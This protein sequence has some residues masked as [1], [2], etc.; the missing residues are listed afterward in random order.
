MLLLPEDIRGTRSNKINSIAKEILTT[1]KKKWLSEHEALIILF[2]DDLLP[3]VLP[4]QIIFSANF[5][6]LERRF[7]F[8]LPPK[9]IAN[10]KALNIFKIFFV[11][12][13]RND[14]AF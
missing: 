7:F 4:F 1:T 9:N 8:R 11:S 5:M 12:T 6:V 10:Q 14:E 3:D 2:L 13:A